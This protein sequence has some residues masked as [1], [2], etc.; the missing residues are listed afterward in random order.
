MNYPQNKEGFYVNFNDITLK[1]LSKK[2][3]K[4]GEKSKMNEKEYFNGTIIEFLLRITDKL[5]KTHLTH[6][7]FMASNVKKYFPTLYNDFL[8]EFGCKEEDFPE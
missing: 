6:M 1:N 7:E 4:R 5:N 3:Q 8:A 2:L